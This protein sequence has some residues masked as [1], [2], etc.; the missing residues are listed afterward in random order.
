VPGAHQAAKL[1]VVV[2][3]VAKTPSASRMTLEKALVADGS[4]VYLVRGENSLIVSDRVQGVRPQVREGHIH[5][6]SRGLLWNVHEW[7]LAQ[8]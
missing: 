2:G 4:F 5:G 7:R 3:Q 8:P 1:P 6:F